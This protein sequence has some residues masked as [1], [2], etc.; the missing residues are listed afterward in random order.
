[1]NLDLFTPTFVTWH[2]WVFVAASVILYFTTLWRMHRSH[3]EGT[4][5]RRK[6][7]LT[8]IQI[9]FTMALFYTG[10]LFKPSGVAIYHLIIISGAYITTV[11]AIIA[12][13]RIPVDRVAGEMIYALREMVNSLEH[14]ESV[15]QS[16][17]KHRDNALDRI[18]QAIGPG[19]FDSHRL[20]RGVSHL[21]RFEERLIKYDRGDGF[22]TEAARPWK[23]LLNEI[24][25]TLQA[26]GEFNETHLKAILPRFSKLVMSTDKVTF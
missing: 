19:E 10:L 17:T 11:I 14:N 23:E 16:S 13:A 2:L 21:A 26:Y 5:V 1:M 22:W 18:R 9:V 6:A 4:P 25:H 3:E 20:V 8:L 12:A 15:V 24:I 7:M